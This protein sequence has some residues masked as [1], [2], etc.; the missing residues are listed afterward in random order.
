MRSSLSLT[1]L[2]ITV[3]TLLIGP[4]PIQSSRLAEGQSPTNA[5]S[6]VLRTTWGAA[7]YA[8]AADGASLWIGATG[9]VVRWDKQ[10]SS[11]RR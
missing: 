5:T 7:Q 8:L 1:V 6:P 3:S 9:S 10:Q 11:Y 2:F 4:A